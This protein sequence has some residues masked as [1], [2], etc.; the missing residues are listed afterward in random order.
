[1]K[2]LLSWL[3]EYAPDIEGDPFALGDLM[4]DLGLTCEEVR[5]L[6][7]GL[8]GIVVARVLS[9]KPHPDAD[10]I[11]L[12]EVDPGDGEALQVC[13]GAF[14]MSVGD[15]VPLATI[16]TVMPGGME[17]A[18]R[19]LR[20]EWSN[21]MLC[22][23]RELD[24]G[25]DHEGILILPA[26]LPVGVGFAEAMGIESDVL[27]DL[28]LT[29][30]R[31]DAYSIIGV[32][33]DVAAKLGIRFELPQIEVPRMGTPTVEI[34]S[35]ELL[36][37]DLCGRF[38][39]RVLSGVTIG[40]SPAHVARRLTLL[41]MRPI[42]SIVDL[43][44]YVMLEYGQ[45]SH[46]FDLD[47][48]PHGALRVRWARAGEQIE[49]LDSQMRTLEPTDG[50][51]AGGD[52][53][54]LSIAGVM[55]GA[56]SEIA[57]GTTNVLLELAWWDPPTIGRTSTRLGLRSEASSRYER[58]VD[59]AIASQAAD[60]F[61]QLAIEEGAT[62]HPGEVVVDGNLPDRSPILVR[63][64]RIN[65]LLGSS[66]DRDQIRGYLDPIGFTTEVTTDGE[67]T[68]ALPSWRL[69]STAEVDIVEEV[70][71]HHGFAELGHTVPV[72]PDP[73][74]LT[75][76][77]LALR[78]IRDVLVDNGCLEVMPNPFLA[79]GELAACGVRT[80]AITVAN[81]LAA[82]E[83]VLRTSL[84]PG[85]LTTLRYNA[86]H[87]QLG[88]P[89]FEIG[90]CYA[91]AAPG[92]GR[93]DTGTLEWAEVAVALEGQEAPA[94]VGLCHR[95]IEELGLPEP[96]VTGAEMPGLHP[97]RSAR[98]SV[99]GVDVGELGE[100]D[101]AVLAGHEIDE[102]VAWLRLDL[103]T[104]LSIERPVHVQK[105]LSRYPSSDIDLA[106]LVPDEVP[107]T[108]PT[109]TLRDASELV[110]SARLFDVFRSDQLP[111]G[112]RNLAYRVRLQAMDRTLTD[113]EVAAVRS[114]LIDAVV[115]THGVE[116]R[117]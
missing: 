15:L 1:M 99:G 93:A 40:P 35:A 113:K 112:V 42:S 23:S 36:D 79:P 48:V 39:L 21:G 111:K 9:L 69:D 102:R 49:T 2:V 32:A 92:E 80:D 8:D 82:D 58:G 98:V 54:A 17:I 10:R 5:L 59:P 31:P 18:R 46:T 65:D 52:D 67:L 88:L 26:D 6:G 47:H 3:R 105:P 108:L 106:F 86:T 4:S 57:E 37:P 43:A 50:V 75:S 91:L 104:L 94:A 24:L 34:A 87:R 13:C 116:L 77:Q 45:P 71:R 83:S 96:L 74:R 64:E 33:R 78:V 61:C 41:G 53:V 56:S 30:N 110:V 14:N 11:Q 68:V 51:I 44:N 97:T 109:H 85:L 114:E 84:L 76:D 101:P 63:T 60:R 55:G 73:G 22:S 89:V 38:A 81:P 95:V 62:I 103:D 20:G 12:V 117:A 107:A 28:D 19:K 100:V 72:P 90:H 70:A 25:D 27:Y 115:T 7:G 16:G 29:P 66:L